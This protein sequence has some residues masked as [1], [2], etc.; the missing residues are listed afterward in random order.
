LQELLTLFRPEQEQVELPSPAHAF[1][2]EAVS[3]V[4]PGTQNAVVHDISFKLQKGSALGVIGPSGGGKSC[5]VR[6]LVG[7]WAPVRGTI[8]LDGAALE[9]WSASLLGK[10]VGYLP[11]D[12]E[13]F[14]GKIAENIARFDSD[15]KDSDILAAAKAAGVHEMIVRMP[16]GYET[17]I[18]E[19]GA[20][21]SA[22][23]RQRI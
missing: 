13:L 6:A 23:Q 15:A 22:G 7:V 2:A 19:G 16:R 5:L 18:G 3:V 9:Q 14:G 1:A 21:L 4:P 17:E 11:Q 8:S 20:A 10:H 12:V